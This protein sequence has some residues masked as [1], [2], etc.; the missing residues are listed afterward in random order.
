L[1]FEVLTL[2]LL[3]PPAGAADAEV[4]QLLNRGDIINLPQPLKD[5][6]AQLIEQPHAYPAVTAFNETTNPGLLFQCYLLDQS[7]FQ[8]NVFT[9]GIQ[10][11]KI[12]HATCQRGARFPFLPYQEI[13]SHT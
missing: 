7:N 5:H 8:P 2:G 10:V 3:T 12:P 6:L 4:D 13:N 11:I 9:T 1:V